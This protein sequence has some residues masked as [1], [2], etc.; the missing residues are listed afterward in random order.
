[1]HWLAIT[2]AQYMYLVLSISFLIIVCRK[3]PQKTKYPCKMMMIK[4]LENLP[5]EERLQ[6]LGLFSLENSW[7]KL[8]HSIS[9][10]KGLLQK[11]QMLYLHK[12]LCGEEKGQ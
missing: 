1:M 6:N 11:G 12:E 5:P 2:S 3:Y 8:H 10:L 7:V 4:V 9:V